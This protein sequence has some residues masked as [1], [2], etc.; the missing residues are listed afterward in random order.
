M[1]WLKMGVGFALFGG[2]AMTVQIAS[3]GSPA[4]PLEGQWGGDRIRLVI[5]SNNGRIETDCASGTIG[6]PIKLGAD[7]KFVA[8][9]TFEQ[10]RGGPQRADEAAAPANARYSGE[11]EQDAMKLS[12]LPVGASAAQVFNLRKGAAVKLVRCL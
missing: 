7:G 11:V 12:I 10:Y 3:A 1:T 4:E 5:D 2:L 6:G 8:S 9:G